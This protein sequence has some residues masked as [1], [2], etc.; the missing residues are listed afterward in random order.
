MTYFFR[1]HEPF[2]ETYETNRRSIYMMQQRIRKNPYLDLFDG[3]D[4]N[5]QFAERRATTTTLQA[6]YLMNS[7]QLHG[8]A[9]R[10]A[11]VIMTKD[12]TDEQRI[13]DLYRSVFGRPAKLEEIDQSRMYFAKS[14]RDSPAWSGYVRAMLSS[15][16]FMFI[17]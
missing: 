13:D 9:D 10:I 4:G 5:I 11:E 15:N 17:D 3:P 6:L 2:Q 8:W 14:G 12:L 16:E 7:E 1:Q